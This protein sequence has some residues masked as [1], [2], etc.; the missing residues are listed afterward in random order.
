MKNRSSLLMV[1]MVVM[2][3]VGAFLVGRRTEQ[4][5]FEKKLKAIWHNKLAGPPQPPRPR[6]LPIVS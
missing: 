5:A 1:S 3:G 6:G 2:I 4:N